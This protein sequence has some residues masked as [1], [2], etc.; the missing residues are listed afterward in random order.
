MVMRRR[1]RAAAR[2]SLAFPNHVDRG[3]LRPTID[4][5]LSTRCRRKLA[6]RDET[7]AEARETLSALSDRELRVKVAGELA[8]ELRAMG[9]GDPA[10]RTRHQCS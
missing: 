9:G 7:I 3:T 4:W 6:L 10:L 8:D 1:D 2:P 5:P